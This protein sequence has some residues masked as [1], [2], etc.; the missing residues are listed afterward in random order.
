MPDTK[1][2]SSLLTIALE[3]ASSLPI[4]YDKRHVEEVDNA[5]RLSG[6]DCETLRRFI[7]NS[8]SC[9]PHIRRL[10]LQNTDRLHRLL[11]RP[12]E[13]TLSDIY[14]AIE[15]KKETI[16]FEK[17]ARVLRLAK[18]KISLLVALCDLS[19]L[20]DD[21]RVMR[22]LS[23]F[24]DKVVETA[25]DKG[26][27]TA[28]QQYLPDHPCPKLSS[29]GIVIYAMGKHG[30]RELNYSSDIDLVLFFSPQKNVSQEQTKKINRRMVKVAVSLLQDQTADGYV[31]RTDLRLRPNPSS[32]D[33]VV[34]IEMARDYFETLGQN[35]ERA[36]F[37]KARLM[38]GDCLVAEQMN[39]VLTPFIWR[40]YLDYAAIADIHSIKRQI[41]AVKGG[42]QFTF[43]GHDLKLGR[44]GIREI[45]FFVQTQQLILG[46][47]NNQL[48][49]KATL[50]GLEALR[51]AGHVTVEIKN[52][53]QDAYLFLRHIEHRIQ[54]IHD[55]QEHAI[56]R[57]EED[58][59]RLACFSGF[60]SVLEFK[61]CVLEVLQRVHYAYAEL[62]YTEEPLSSPV[63]SLVFTGVEDDPE[64]IKTLQQLGFQ[65][66]AQISGL[67]R[68][69]HAGDIRATRTAR[70]R[71]NLTRLVPV[72]IDSAASAA[73]PDQA[74]YAF[75]GFLRQLPAGIQ[76]FSLIEQHPTILHELIKLAD[77]AP[78]LA[79]QMA[80]HANY[81]ELILEQ[82]LRN[83]EN[84]L[85][86]PIK[87]NINN[88]YTEES[89]F[90]EFLD[91]LR[92]HIN[93]NRFRLSC[94]IVQGAR[95]MREIATDLSQNAMAAIEECLL[96]IQRELASKYGAM[97]GHLAVIAL[98]R[99]GAHSLTVNS[100]LD[101][102]FVYE[103]FKGAD[104]NSSHVST[105]FTRYVRRIIT[106]LSA[107][108]SR[109]G[110]YEID[111]AL[112]PSGTAGPVA[113]HINT[114][115]DYYNRQAWTWEVMA[116][117]KADTVSSN[118]AFADR[119]NAEIETFLT[120]PRD[121]ATLRSDVIDM[122]E[123]LRAHKQSENLWDVK[124]LHGGLTDID[125]ICQYL[126]LKEGQAIG[127]A[128]SHII[129]ALSLLAQQKK[130]SCKHQ[131]ELTTAW[132]LYDTILQYG[133]VI[134][135]GLFNPSMA[136]NA[137]KKG[138]AV[139]CHVE[140]IEQVEQ[141]IAQH[142]QTICK[143]FLELVEEDS[144]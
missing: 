116:L 82:L 31:F 14:A 12:P 111:M 81:V 120:R 136:S 118:A 2:L 11:A 71:E 69:W 142:A 53:L 143:L 57:S 101:L 47:K 126:C 64:T 135:V 25:F 97:P 121:R 30:G 20:W 21:Q 15:L 49:E 94:Q 106:A 4:C 140:T 107:Q 75:D 88:K 124:N 102:I 139:R 24:A 16:H 130:L 7:A 91:V 51:A 29:S 9:S 95:P 92:Q 70:A 96:F 8:A 61:Q 42:G 27:M 22:V 67:I 43:A 137:E 65:H 41:H 33:A 127:R 6:I 79:K 54:M 113:V 90:E 68:R 59:Q 44:G 58:I 122:R 125:F 84:R 78:R 66:P 13:A 131:R 138:L 62:F 123:R 35:W 73:Y 100:D 93:E 37:I 40:K 18:A 129:E 39:E 48:R 80:Q 56:G 89:T 112:R 109:G 99:L 85:S 10:I 115:T 144:N 117:L 103:P 114:F 128:P 34:S 133:R 110:L 60:S 119:V 134:N 36:A 104:D 50:E 132:H 3:D 46:G 45:E 5:L 108:T 74:F 23:D 98:G 63:G 19:G 55:Q 52:S 28:W 77:M 86:H 38:A 87:L 141:K 1:S 32:S 17:L 105:W 72:I 83:K 76:I 26:L